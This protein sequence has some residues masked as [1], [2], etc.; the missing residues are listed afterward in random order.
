MA[1]RLFCPPPWDPDHQPKSRIERWD[2]T[3]L[4][5]CAIG[6][7]EDYSKIDKGSV[8]VSAWSGYR[9]SVLAVTPT[10]IVMTRNIR[11]GPLQYIRK[12]WAGPDQLYR[13]DRLG[14][15]CFTMKK[16]K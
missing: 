5:N 9:Y 3:V 4:A 12:E 6:R 11:P 16:K 14:Q 1:T 15:P 7:A 8:L 10:Y 2:T 13:I